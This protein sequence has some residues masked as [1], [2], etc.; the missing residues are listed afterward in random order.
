MTASTFPRWAGD[1][2]PRFVY[3][4]CCALSNDFE[5][6]ALV[7]A[8]PGA[9]DEEQLGPV[10]VIRYHYFPIHRLETLCYPGAIVPRIKE[11]KVRALLVPFLFASLWWNVWRRRRRFDAV[12]AHWLIPQGI[13]QSFV[14]MPYL[15]T[16]HG[17]DLSS[18]NVFPLRQL[19]ARCLRR[20]AA[21]TVVSDKLRTV[22]EQLAPG[23]PCRVQ[24]MGCDTSAFSPRNR[25]P[26][27]F[28]PGEGPVVLFVGRLEEIKGLPVLLRAME[29]VDARL[30][31]AGSGT[32]L[33][34]WRAQAMPLGERVLFLGQ[35]PR[36]RL[37]VLYA[38]AD[39]LCAPSLVMPDGRAEGFGLVLLEAMASGTPVVASWSGG[40]AELVQDGENGLLTRPGDADHLAAALNRVLQDAG[41][42]SQL[43]QRGMQTALQYSF[44]AVGQAY[45]ALLRPLTEERND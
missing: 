31:V 20:A 39:V 4:L 41:L 17:S 12:H 14:K 3:D 19:K 30:V 7:P 42:R 2:E 8:C 23:V 21:V 6:T 16:G 43:V 18:L 15:V 25:R 38:S 36:E 45:A 33:E 9:A 1:S 22:V 28:G 26:D 34:A 29:Q 35:V 32:M 40:M 37:R 5:V 24:P 44:S 10:H 13:V 11:K 27:A